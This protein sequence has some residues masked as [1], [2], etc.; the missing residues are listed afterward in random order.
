LRFDL[1]LE[2]LA[3]WLDLEAA[4]ELADEMTEDAIYAP[5]L[6][7]QEAE[8]RE[9][10]ASAGV[11]LGHLAFAAVPGL[12]REMVERLEAARPATLAEAARVRGITPAALA[13]ILVNARRN[14][15]AA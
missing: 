1:Q 4:G 8:L 15:A 5:Y 7:R 2:Q 12:S 9:M 10:R 6:E 14:A 13:A 3:P 11:T